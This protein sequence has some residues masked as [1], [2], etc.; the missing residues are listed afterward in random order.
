M[1]LAVKS[2]V[3]WSVSVCFLSLQKSLAV[4]MP[5]AGGPKLHTVVFRWAGLTEPECTAII[6]SKRCCGCEWKLHGKYLVNGSSPYC[7]S[8]DSLVIR[9]ETVMESGQRFP[10]VWPLENTIL[11]NCV[12]FKKSLL[13]SHFS[14]VPGEERD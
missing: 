8:F 6:R 7:Y 4:L 13:D 12:R 14:Q 10:C 5:C 1:P 9:T 2:T 3:L 11:W